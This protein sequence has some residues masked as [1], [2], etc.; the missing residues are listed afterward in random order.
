MRFP[1]DNE[2]EED[3]W[4]EEMDEL[5]ETDRFEKAKQKLGAVN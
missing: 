1:W 2:E 3:I 5:T 4:G